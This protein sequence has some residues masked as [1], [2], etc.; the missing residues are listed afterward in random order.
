MTLLQKV[1][2][3]PI[4]HPPSVPATRKVF[5]TDEVRNLPAPAVFYQP[6]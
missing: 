3:T 4:A 5:L 2:Q 6:E 1:P